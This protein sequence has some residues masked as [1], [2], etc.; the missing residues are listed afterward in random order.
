[1]AVSNNYLQYVLEQ[2]GALGDVRQRRMFGA[3]GLYSGE[4]FFAVIS[5]DELYFKVDDTTRP[6]Y[7]QRGMKA[8]QPKTSRGLISTR[9]FEVPAEVLEDSGELLDWAHRSVAAAA[10]SS[11]SAGSSK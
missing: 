8:F 2:L 7:E 9:Y 3:V 6:A 5:N 10:R 4:L 1:M 11:S